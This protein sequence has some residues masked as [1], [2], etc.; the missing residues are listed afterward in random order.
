MKPNSNA[1]MVFLSSWNSGNIWDVL[2]SMK[3]IQSCTVISQLTRE[4]GTATEELSGVF[5]IAF[6]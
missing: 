1:E 3:K 4:D 5:L 2:F 6:S